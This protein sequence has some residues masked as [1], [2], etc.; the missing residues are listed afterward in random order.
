MTTAL[1]VGDHS[2]IQGFLEFGQFRDERISKEE[3]F[4][5]F[6]VPHTLPVRYPL[7]KRSI[8]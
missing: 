4:K 2:K 7:E 5:A 3:V 1:A 6:E 8:D